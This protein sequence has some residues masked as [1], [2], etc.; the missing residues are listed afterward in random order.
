MNS[1]SPVCTGLIGAPVDR[2]LLLLSKGYNCGEAINEREMCPWDI[3]II[4]LVIRCPTHC[5][6]FICAN[7]VRSANQRERYVSGLSQLFLVTDMF[8]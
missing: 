2:K 6:E 8:I 3:S 5:F 4:V 7:Q 1:A